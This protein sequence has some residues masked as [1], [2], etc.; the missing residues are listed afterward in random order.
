MLHGSGGGDGDDCDD[1][2]Y[3]VDFDD[4]YCDS[5]VDGYGSNFKK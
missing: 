4:H 2:D 5:D 1:C 3:V